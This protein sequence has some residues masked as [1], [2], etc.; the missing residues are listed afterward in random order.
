MARKFMYRGKTLEELQAMKIEDFVKL[1]PA[2]QRRSM[3]RGFDP[4]RKKFYQKVKKAKESGNNI[5]LRTHARDVIITPQMVNLT[6]EVYN[7]KEWH[8]VTIKPEMIGHY[9]GEF[10]LTRRKVSHGM[11]GMGATRS[12]LYVPLK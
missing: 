3:N 8:A 2:R 10:V 6:I 11:P 4:R 9:L 7:G 12:S 1:L 5:K